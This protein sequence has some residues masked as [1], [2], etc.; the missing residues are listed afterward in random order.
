MNRLRPIAVCACLAG[1]LLAA[2]SGDDSDGAGRS[3][4]SRVATSTTV[5]G[6]DAT[7]S[8]TGATTTIAPGAGPGSNVLPAVAVGEPAELAANLSVT[9]TSIEAT[10]LTAEGPGQIAGPGVIVTVE[11][12]N[13]TDA[14]VDLAGIAVNAHYGGDVPAPPNVIPGDPLRG[15]VAPGARATGQ[16]GF[17]VPEDQAS[18]IVIDV[19]HSGA[20]NLV[21]VTAGP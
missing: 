10:N 19:Q 18:T 17:R 3:T 14:P 20:P 6:D 5:A 4:S 8:S 15:R 1:L 16:Y 9:V 13:D 12:R 21:V 2:C 7:T 11:V